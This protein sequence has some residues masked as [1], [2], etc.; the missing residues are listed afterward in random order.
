MDDLFPRA[1][2][3]PLLSL[4]EAS[5]AVLVHGPRG[6][7]KRT[8][9]GLATDGRDYEIVDL[10]DPAFRN[11]AAAD[12]AGF[13]WDLPPFVILEEIQRVPALLGV[14]AVEAVRDPVPGR[15]IATSA[16]D[17]QPDGS[18]PPGIDLFRLDPRASSV[19]G[20]AGSW[21]ACSRAGSSLAHPSGW[22]S[23]WWR[24][25][26]TAGSP[27]RFLLRRRTREPR[28][29]SATCSTW[30]NATSTPIP[31]FAHRVS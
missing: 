18:V 9:V 4:L 15:F 26:W 28:G 22:G 21:N 25:S 17:T 20:T 14:I 12:P 5:P 7:G 30:W 8:L 10:E 29:T 1:A 24:G 27:R 16:L 6:S 23:S 2:L 13:V 3:L 19:S 11:A 31:A